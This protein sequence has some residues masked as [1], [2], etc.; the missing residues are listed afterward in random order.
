M[1]KTVEWGM[2]K[3]QIQ[4]IAKIIGLILNMIQDHDVDH[5]YFINDEAMTL[6]YI[7]T[8]LIDITNKGVYNQEERKFLNQVRTLVLN[9]KQLEKRKKE[10]MPWDDPSYD[11]NLPFLINS[12]G[13]IN[14]NLTT[15]SNGAAKHLFKAS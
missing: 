8:K 14:H 1:S 7:H 10:R 3:E 15:M 12:K 13:Q 11:N 2:G 6:S 5:R 4:G 9:Y